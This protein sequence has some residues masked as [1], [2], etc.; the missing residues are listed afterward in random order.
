MSFR[1]FAIVPAAGHSRRMG[2]PKL[3][4]PWGDS[5]IVQHVLSAWRASSVDRIIAV[6]RRDDTALQ[7]LV[8]GERTD[9]VLPMVDPPDMK[10]SVQQALAY[11]QS[12]YSPQPSDVWLMAPADMPYLSAQV[13]ER[14]LDAYSPDR[15]RILVPDLDG[16][17]GHP[18][19]F[20]WAMQSRV[21]TLGE[22]EGIRN[23]VEANSYERVGIIVSD[24]FAEPGTASNLQEAASQLGESPQ[25]SPE[26]TSQLLE[27]LRRF[28]K[29]I[30]TVADYQFEGGAAPIS[31]N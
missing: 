24:V 7:K 2:L 15:P 31:E 21:N 10:A 20:P 13:I 5:T 14:L 3:M 8:V 17:R 26:S 19:L 25:D 22:N 4:L 6:V 9:M 1:R 18:V 12:Q 30:D 11:V 29:D 28:R 27:A 23:L 16:H